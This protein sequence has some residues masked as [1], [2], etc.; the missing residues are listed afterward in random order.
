[1]NIKS[2]NDSCLLCSPLQKNNRIDQ[3]LTEVKH[4]TTPKI[5]KVDNSPICRSCMS[6]LTAYGVKISFSPPRR[7]NDIP[8]LIDA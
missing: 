2:Q 6:R 1:M 7:N 3:I 5:L 4:S 8:Q